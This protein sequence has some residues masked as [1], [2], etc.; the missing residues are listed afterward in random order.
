MC[1]DFHYK[2][3]ETFFILRI[4]KRDVIEN[5]MYALFLSGLM[6][7]VFSP[8]IFKNCSNIKFHA[9]PSSGS[10]VVPCGRRDRLTKL[11][12]AFRSFVNTPKDG[13]TTGCSWHKESTVLGEL[14][15]LWDFGTSLC[16]FR[17]LTVDHVPVVCITKY[18]S[19]CI[20]LILSTSCARVC[21]CWYSY[22]H[23]VRV[24][25]P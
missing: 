6:K 19:T 22:E 12:A 5:V 24:I 3:S 20:S 25:V 11:I 15:L 16:A 14:L 8:Y 4:H 23:G 17:A 21:G 1:F 9:N 2:F 18:W 10:R 7:L 13:I